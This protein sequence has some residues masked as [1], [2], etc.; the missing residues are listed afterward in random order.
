MI[1]VSGLSV[2]YPGKEVLRDCSLHIPP[3]QHAALMGP[4][5]CGK[6]TLFRVLLGLLPPEKGSV[7][8]NGRVSCAFQEPRLLPW[9]TV[10]QNVN[11][12]LSD[13][14]ETLPEAMDWL[15][16]VRLAEAAA[17]YPAQLSGGMLQRVSLARALA[18]GG[19]VLLLDEPLKGLDQ[20]L[21]EELTSLLLENCRGRTLLLVTH[22]PAEAALLVD[23]LYVFR[24]G[25]FVPGE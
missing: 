12:V 14:K 6:T 16:R 22:D 11:A 15:R 23:S 1:R 20:A 3:G 25:S 8:V 19:D 18:F 7:E 2:G 10:L 21:K 24:D 4:S 5:G 13:K 9:R 17:R